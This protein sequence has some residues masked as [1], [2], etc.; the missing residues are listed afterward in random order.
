MSDFGPSKFL[1][2]GHNAPSDGNANI[3]FDY[4]NDNNISTFGQEAVKAGYYDPIAKVFTITGHVDKDVVS[5]VALQDNPNEDAP[6]NR[7]AIDK[8]GNF[9][10][11]FHMD[12]PSTRQLTY[13]YKVKDSSTDKIDTVKVRL[14]LFLIQ[15]CQLCMLIN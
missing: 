11:K 5:L 14:L 13:I 7:V 9:I 15:F 10:I 8:D 2:P 1:Y 6:E 12:D 4:V 3:S